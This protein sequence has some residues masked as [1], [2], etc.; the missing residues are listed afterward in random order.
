MD[1]REDL[2]YICDY[3]NTRVQVLDMEGRFVRKW[4][5]GEAIPFHTP[6]DIVLHPYLD[7][8]FV[9][10]FHGCRIRRYRRDGTLECAWGS[11]GMGAG[12]FQ[13][14]SYMALS[15]SRGLLFVT[16]KKSHRV[17]A[18]TLSG[19]FVSEWVDEV[20]FQRPG[21]IAVDDSR[22]RVYVCDH[23]TADVHVFSI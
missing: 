13:L 14:C 19:E 3:G 16:D 10:D 11:K 7:M 4:S 21:V 2:L 6:R 5:S 23:E 20:R 8:V 18:F 17:Q 1:S 15:S 12:R 22:D 9:A